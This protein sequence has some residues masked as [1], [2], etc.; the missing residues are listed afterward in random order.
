MF[1]ECKLT[2]QL[3]AVQSLCYSIQFAKMMEISSIFFVFVL[4]RPFESGFKLLRNFIPTA[5]VNSPLFKAIIFSLIGAY[6]VSG[7]GWE[8]M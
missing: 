7:G 5:G 8:G 3:Y 4:Y 6:S 1:Q 2:V